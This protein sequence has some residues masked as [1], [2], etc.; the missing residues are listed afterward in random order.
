MHY[1]YNLDPFNMYRDKELWSAL[2]KCHVKHTIKALAGQ[3]DA[4]IVENGENF[5]VGERQ[6]ICMARALLRQSKILVLDEATAAIDTE[7]DSL[8]Q[9]TIKEVFSDCTM[10]TIAH[11]LN[12]ITNYDRI[13][14]LDQ[15]QVIEFDTPSAL[16]ANENSVF[17]QMVAVQ[18]SQK[19]A[20][21]N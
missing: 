11:R 20:A 17:S 12:T 9:E 15:G 16:L 3:L 8:V 13:L 18:D 6:L 1:R 2:R 19:H 10:L 4:P 5:S 7:T 21:V 14:V